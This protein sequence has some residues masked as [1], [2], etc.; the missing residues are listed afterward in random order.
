MHVTTHK[1]DAGHGDS[2]SGV[3]WAC[4]GSH[5][6]LFGSTVAGSDQLHVNVAT[7]SQQQLADFCYY[8]GVCVTKE[9]AE[10]ANEAL[11]EKVYVQFDAVYAPPVKKG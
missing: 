6:Y 10:T 4:V 1:A 5:S 9:L 11:E 7:R 3:A 8:T 2:G